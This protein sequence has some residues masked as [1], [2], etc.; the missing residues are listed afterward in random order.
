MSN[1]KSTKYF[2]DLVVSNKQNVQVNELDNLKE[3]VKLEFAI[4]NSKKGIY[5]T[6]KL[7]TTKHFNL[8]NF[9]SVIIFLKRN[10][11]FKLLSLKIIIRLIL[12]Q[13]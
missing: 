9:L 4:E 7:S 12:I 3:K 2:N 11:I 1:K 10:K 8:K 6:R 5:S 13:L